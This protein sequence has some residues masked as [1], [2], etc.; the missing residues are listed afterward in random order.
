LDV[1]ARERQLQES[2]SVKELE[3]RGLAIRDL[4]L[5]TEYLIPCCGEGGHVEVKFDKESGFS[6][7][8]SWK[9]GTLIIAEFSIDGTFQ[10]LE[11]WSS[12]EGIISAVSSF[13]IT[14]R[15]HRLESFLLD[16]FV[17]NKILAELRI[18]KRGYR[19]ILGKQLRMLKNMVGQTI[20]V[21]PNWPPGVIYSTLFSNV[22]LETEPRLQH[23]P[24]IYDTRIKQ[25]PAKVKAI[26]MCSECPPVCLIHGPPG[27]GK[28]TALAAAVLSAVA[29][30][31]K[32]LVAAPSHAACDAFTLA[33]AEQWP[34]ASQQ[35]FVRLGTSLRFTSSAVKS[36]S[37]H[38]LSDP[39]FV[40][41]IEEDL[42]FTRRQLIS[43]VKGKEDIMRAEVHLKRK[44]LKLSRTNEKEL[45]ERSSVVIT[46]IMNATSLEKQ[47]KEKVFDLVVIDEAGFTPANN[48]LPL[49][50]MSP[51]LVLAGDHH[52]LPPVV[53]TQ[54]AKNLGLDKSIFELLA[55]R[56]KNNV[57]LLETQYRS[58]SLISG[59]SNQHFYESK[60]NS[61]KKNSD[62]L[63]NDLLSH[64]NNRK[65][66]N[67]ILTTSPLLY[68][69]TSDMDWE[70]DIED[71]DSISNCAEAVFVS[72]LVDKFIALGVD[73][74]SVGVI[75]P[76]WS[77]IALIRSLV[78]EEA[79]LREIEI[80]TVDGFQGREKEV[81][82][83]SL[84]RSNDTSDIGFLAETRRIN[85][86]VTRA[87]RACVIVGD[88][89]TL[90]TDP[91]LTSLHEY[92]RKIDAL[93][94]VHQIYDLTH[95]I[96]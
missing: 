28:T 68:V 50:C 62:I 21:N 14:I 18:I 81:I 41:A 4:K 74:S 31:E 20:S 79:G 47:I 13:S 1:E 25:D 42:A 59:W 40:H 37:V 85:V 82:I 94:T 66:K 78:W 95:D 83:L 96:L 71:E 58:N 23:T 76:Y 32:V 49:M 64:N 89:G 61:F 27:T 9:S 73:Q 65:L 57:V 17:K 35:S 56:M 54:E 48:V 39:A 43:D 87:K 22:V 67:N 75:A 88:S 45:I 63:V 10:D 11:K 2:L 46:T 7:G 93:Y 55:G 8:T 86:S 80:R 36:Y 15:F 92:C 34:K 12:L 52:Q 90:N 30:G 84:V 16:G 29:N 51:R 70:E 5:D 19:T 72:E 60:L 38:H 91:G 69:D 3:L 53:Q 6:G 24:T 26:L 33:L 44:H 77:Q